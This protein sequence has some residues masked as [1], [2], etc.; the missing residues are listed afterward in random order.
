MRRLNR[1]VV[2]LLAGLLWVSAS[3]GATPQFGLRTDSTLAMEPGSSFTV[4]VDGYDLGLV[5]AY[6]AQIR[7]PGT[8]LVLNQINP[9]TLFAPGTFL[10]ITSMSSAKFSAMLITSP[11]YQDA[12]PVAE[13][14][15]FQLTVPADAQ[16]GERVIS[17]AGSNHLNDDGLLVPCAVPGVVKIEVAAPALEVTDYSLTFSDTPIGTTKHE[18]FGIHNSG[19]LGT[20]LNGQ[21]GEPQLLLYNNQQAPSGMANP[22][23]LEDYGHGSLFDLLGESTDTIGYGI[24][25]APT[26]EGCYVGYVDIFSDDGVGGTAPGASTSRVYFYGEAIPEP[27]TLAVLSTGLLGLLRRRTRR[28]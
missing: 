16:L 9:G 24:D 12:G 18:A 26:I 28:R 3:S 17:A 5:S 23:S 25:F 6:Q 7:M 21:M 13:M 2:A 14:A 11:Y 22:F 4:F 8:G 19:L 27:A 15:S 20:I 1:I 10:P